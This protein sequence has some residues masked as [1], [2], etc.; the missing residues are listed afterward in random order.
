LAQAQ[1]RS[2]I[3]VIIAAAFTKLIANGFQP[4]GSTTAA[5]CA[6]SSASI[7]LTS[8]AGEIEQASQQLY[9]SSRSSSASDSARFPNTQKICLGFAKT[10]IHIVMTLCLVGAIARTTLL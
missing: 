2:A 10:H 6:S 4:N 1:F 3:R 9:H 8:I 7:S 5:I